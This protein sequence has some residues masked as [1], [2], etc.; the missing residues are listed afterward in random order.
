MKVVTINNYYLFK[1]RELLK[2]FINNL[3]TTIN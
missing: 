1:D 3:V 2:K